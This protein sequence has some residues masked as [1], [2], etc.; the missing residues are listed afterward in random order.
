MAEP[1][2]FGPGA[3]EAEDQVSLIP[4]VTSPLAYRR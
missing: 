1:K 2:G 4:P 3:T